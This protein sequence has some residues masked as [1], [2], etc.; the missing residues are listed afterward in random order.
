MPRYFPS[1]EEF[2]QVVSTG[3]QVVPV[4]R[5][6]LADRLTPVTAFELLAGDARHAFLLESVVGIE[7]I[8][9]YSF[10]ATSPSFVY[11]AKDG[12]VAM[13]G[14]VTHGQDARDTGDPLADLERL[15]PMKRYHHDKRLPNFTGGL[16]GYAGY[17]TIRYYEGEKL[18][19]PPAD[20]R[21]LPDVMFGL[22]GELVIFD[23]LDKTI[24]VVANADVSSGDPAGVYRGAC[25]RIDA[26]VA[27]LQKPIAGESG[28]ID[29]SGPVSLTFQSNMTRQQF[30]QAVVAG[31]EYI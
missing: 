17:D 31:K 18:T 10:I 28:E 25:T 30:E 3:A 27:R 21:N 29:P 7:K 13:T 11:E 6:L 22:Y 5:Q 26:L 16:V 14:S 19:A 9:R 24:K 23:H 12:R 1:A 20:D 4:W 2:G 8:G 15:L